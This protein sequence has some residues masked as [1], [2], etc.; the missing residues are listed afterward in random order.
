MLREFGF[1][2]YYGFREGISVS[3]A[4]DAN[5]P[6][7]ISN[8]DPFSTIMG[9]KGANASGKTTVLRG[10]SFLSAFAARS[11]S[12]DPDD[13]IPLVVHFDSS[14]PCELYAEFDVNGVT[15]LYEASLGGNQVVSE[16]LY[17]TKA[18]KV[19]IIERQGNRLVHTIGEF[20]ALKVM[21]LR[22][23]ASV[24]STTK[25]YGLPGLEDVHSFF[26]KVVSNVGFTGHVYDG[27]N[28]PAVAAELHHDAEKRE[29][30]AKF[31]KSIDVGVTEISIHESV[32]RDPA[33]P[34]KEKKKYTPFFQ[35]G[36]TYLQSI[37]WHTESNGTRALFNRL[38]KIKRALDTG[39]LLVADEFDLHLH[40]MILPKLLNMFTDQDSNPNGA[41]LI[42]TTHDD[43]VLDYLGKYRCY[44]INKRDNESFGYRLDELPGDVLR[45]DRAVAPAYRSG[46]I[47][48]LPRV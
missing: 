46:K 29:F 48:G 12:Y 38:P 18:K 10:I 22:P 2:N 25:Q 40:P 42:F 45:N 4:L 7:H 36:E 43:D 11:F 17:R 9:V 23:N 39:G 13:P 14:D 37:T 20:D 24:I 15:Y 28:S 47:G 41:Q 6:A 27:S 5:C 8:G 35:H 1:K 44:L 21:V 3:F 16:T 33:D 34:S 19:K 30:V 31:I 26:V 32:E